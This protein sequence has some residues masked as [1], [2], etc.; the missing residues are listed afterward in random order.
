MSEAELHLLAGR[1]QGA[2]LAKQAAIYGILWRTPRDS[3]FPQS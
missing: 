2:K 1:L 3:R